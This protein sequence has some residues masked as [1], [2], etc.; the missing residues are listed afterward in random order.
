MVEPYLLASSIEG[1]ASV[2]RVSGVPVDVDFEKIL[3]TLSI[4]AM[5]HAEAHHT[6]GWGFIVDYGFMDL[7]DDIS[8]PRGGVVSSEIM[9][10]IG[11][12]V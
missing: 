5:V 11:V 4:G 8:T 7:E 6:N 2:G 12:E 3:E 1:D 9:S 10:N